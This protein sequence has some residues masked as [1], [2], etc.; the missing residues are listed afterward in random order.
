MPHVG[1]A[2]PK[3]GAHRK[4]SMVKADGSREQRQREGSCGP[5]GGQGPDPPG[6]TGVEDGQSLVHQGSWRT[7]TA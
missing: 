3:T 7:E 2:R 4:T 5:K 6:R 1:E